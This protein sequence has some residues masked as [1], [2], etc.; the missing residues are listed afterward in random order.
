MYP[1]RC[2]MGL[3]CSDIA[4]ALLCFKTDPYLHRE[5]TEWYPS[6]HLSGN[7]RPPHLYTKFTEKAPQI[8]GTAPVTV[9]ETEHTSPPPPTALA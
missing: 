8:A 4:K 9:T 5:L 7:C 1:V 6:I 3:N 2:T